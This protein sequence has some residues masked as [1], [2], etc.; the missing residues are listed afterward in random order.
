[1][2]DHLGR[3]VDG[4]FHLF[5]LIQVGEKLI[6][7]AFSAGI[8]RDFQ[9]NQV[10]IGVQRNGRVGKTHQVAIFFMVEKVDFIAFLQGVL[11]QIPQ[12]L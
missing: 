8:S 5:E 4:A 10:F 12:S 6:A 9:A 1:M 2:R 7:G 11:A 3:C